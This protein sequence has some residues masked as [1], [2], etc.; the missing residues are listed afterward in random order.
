MAGD[1]AAFVMIRLSFTDSTIY[2]AMVKIF[3]IRRF[4]GVM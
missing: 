4:A 2:I 3:G 1:Y